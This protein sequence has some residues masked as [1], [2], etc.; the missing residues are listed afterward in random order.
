MNLRNKLTK[1]KKPVMMDRALERQ[2]G[3]WGREGKWK[4][5]D[6]LGEAGDGASTD[7]LP[8]LTEGTVCL[9]PRYHWVSWPA[10]LQIC[11]KI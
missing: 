6:I 11:A 7:T 9:R 1:R 8:S 4:E 10:I 2:A 5:L 3:R